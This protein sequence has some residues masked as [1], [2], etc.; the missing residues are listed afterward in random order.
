[1]DRKASL[2]GLTFG[3]TKGHLVRATLESIC[4]QVKA[5]IHAM[6]QDLQQPMPQIAMHGGLSKNTFVQNG[7]GKFNR[8]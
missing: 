4:F 6:E 5:V 8:C 2:H 1:M 7:L 3:T